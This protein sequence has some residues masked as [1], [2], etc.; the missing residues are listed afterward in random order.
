MTT[1]YITDSRFDAHTLAGHV[2]VAARLV[3]IR[4]VMAAQ[5]LPD[6]MLAVTPVEATHDQLCAVHTGEYL[7][8]LTWTETQRGLMLGPDTY[9]LPESFRVARLSAGAAISGVDAVLKGNAD[10]VLVCARPPGH[11]ATPSMGM[12]F[13][14]LSNVALAVRHA[15]R[16]YGLNRVMIVDYDVHHGNG[17]QDAFYADPD[18]MFVSTHQ[19]PWYP[20]TGALTEI[21]TG[22]GKGTT[23]NVPLPAG[24]G[25]KGYAQVF[26]RIVWPVAWRFQP[27]L[28]VVSAGFDAHWADQLGQIKLTLSGYNHLTRELIRMAKTLCGGKVVFVLEGGYNLTSLSN[29]VANVAY[30]LL[31]DSQHLDP[32][33][34]ASGTEP[35]IQPL[36]AE[37]AALHGL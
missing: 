22:A 33:G 10:N 30:A 12:G 9:V 23:V 25:D 7:D 26:E 8:L 18:V 14:L 2:E 17:T 5:H 21:G 20:G 29:G 16:A 13:C 11:H 35:D 32:L 19:Y 3:A 34:A 36:I 27:E 37:I 24:T 6:R 31:Q 15:Q 28:I 4:D 1:A